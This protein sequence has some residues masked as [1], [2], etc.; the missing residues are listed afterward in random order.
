MN[1]AQTQ[2]MHKK[3]ARNVSLLTTH[4]PFEITVVRDADE[5]SRNI[6]GRARKNTGLAMELSAH[7]G[8]NNK[9]ARGYRK[10]SRSV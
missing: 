5:S 7:A 2:S 1:D 8:N 3:I 4:G 9:Q 6:C 10:C